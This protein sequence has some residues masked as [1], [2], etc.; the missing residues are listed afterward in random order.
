MKNKVKTLSIVWLA[1]LLSL[2]AWS[3]KTPVTTSKTAKKIDKTFDFDQ[4]KELYLNLKYANNI[5]VKTWNQNK[6]KV[7]AWVDINGGKHN[8]KF[9]LATDKGSGDFEIRSRIKDLSKITKTLIVTGDEHNNYQSYGNVTVYND[10]DGTH[11]VNGRFLL[12]SIRYEVN[13]PASTKQ[14]KIKTI[15]GNIEMQHPKNCQLNLKSISGFIDV[16]IASGQKA[17]LD[18]RSYSG[19]VFSDLP[20]KIK[21]PTKVGK[22]YRKIGG[23]ARL[24]GKLNGGGTELRLK[25]F[26]GN[27]YLRKAK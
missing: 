1:I 21:P 16:S 9:E 15:S 22:S 27:I 10:E 5:K 26:Q 25:S 12:A 7:T 6:V 11:Q 4:S 13:V 14:L 24:K 2:Q 17:N 18:M 20:I 3:Q 19:D 8:D 23:R